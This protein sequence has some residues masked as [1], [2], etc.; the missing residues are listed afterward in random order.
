MSGKRSYAIIWGTGIVFWVICY[1]L[2]VAVVQPKVVYDAA[3]NAVVSEHYDFGTVQ[4]AL[5]RVATGFLLPQVGLLGKEN[6]LNVI[7]PFLV[8]VL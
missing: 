8:L 7:E 3:I 2:T 6:V 5:S 1:I 4:V